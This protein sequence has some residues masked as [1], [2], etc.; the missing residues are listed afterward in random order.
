MRRLRKSRVFIIFVLALAIGML[1]ASC[2]GDKETSPR[3]LVPEGANLISEVNLAAILA[4]R[5]LATSIDAAPKSDD[6]PQS[7]DELLDEAYSETGIDIRQVSQLVGFGSGL[8]VFLSHD[9]G[10]SSQAEPLLGIIVK[11]ALDEAVVIAAMEKM[12]G[13]RMS[14]SDYKGRRVYR[15][16]VDGEE[17]FQRPALAFLD[18]DILALGTAERSKR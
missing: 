10:N 7:L 18:G 8:P 11:S 1:A 16:E 3:N 9:G 14:T 13:P 12:S 6:D 5:G 17:L 15:P 2:G 4:S